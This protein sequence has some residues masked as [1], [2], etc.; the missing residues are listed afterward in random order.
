MENV[1]EQRIN[2]A[3]FSSPGSQ[4]KLAF[5]GEGGTMRVNLWDPSLGNVLVNYFPEVTILMPNLVWTLDGHSTWQARTPGFRL[6]SCLNLRSSWDY[7]AGHPSGSSSRERGYA[8]GSCQFP[9][10]LSPPIYLPPEA[11]GSGG[12]DSLDPLWILS[13]EPLRAEWDL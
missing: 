4:H 3:L 11:R 7:R 12:Y 8:N 9:A 6:F 1:A 2:V 13:R 5:K 10:F